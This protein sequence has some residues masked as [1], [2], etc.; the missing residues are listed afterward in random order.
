MA[1]AIGATYS[2]LVDWVKRQDPGGGIAK[3]IEVLSASNPILQDANVMEGNLPTG[4]R[5]TQRLSQPSGSWRLLNAGISAEKSTTKQV[6]DACGMLESYSRV[7]VDLASLNGNEKAYRASE[8]MA[9]VSGLNSAAATAL[10]YGNQ[11]TDP[12]QIQGFSTRYNSTTGDYSSQII[13]ASGSGSDNTSIWLITW[14]PQTCTLIYPKGSQAG[15]TAE[16][17][18]K[19]LVLDGSGNTYRAWV[20]WFQWKLGL[21]LMDYRHVIRICNIDVSDLTADAAAGADLMDKMVD[22]YFSLPSERVAME[23]AGFAKTYWYCNKT[24]AKYLAKQASNKSNVN[25]TIDYPAG[26]PQVSFYTI[27]IHVCDNIVSTESAV[28]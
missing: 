27:P 18:G 13:N 7:D 2:T 3:V 10:F 21:A 1:T 20:T 24:V 8:D 26:K 23:N 28:S 15:L 16:D 5:S 11:G 9:F 6:D 17:M 12:E 14:S 4:H 22:A 25:L 19:Q